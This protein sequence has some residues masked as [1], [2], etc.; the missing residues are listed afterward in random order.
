M[1]GGALLFNEILEGIASLKACRAKRKGTIQLLPFQKKSKSH[2]IIKIVADMPIRNLNFE[3]DF[4]SYCLD[5]THHSCFRS[6]CRIFLNCSELF[7]NFI[8]DAFSE[9]IVH[10]DLEHSSKYLLAARLK[11]SPRMVKLF[12]VVRRPMLICV[13]EVRPR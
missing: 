11:F 5:L 2:S 13:G 6:Y 8:S 3:K 4:R 10:K 7:G 1:P 9:V 12:L